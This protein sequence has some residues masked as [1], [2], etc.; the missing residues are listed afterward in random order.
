[1]EGTRQSGIGIDLKIA[2]LGADGQILQYARNVAGEIIDADPA[3]TDPA[4][5]LL[6]DRL[7]ILFPHK[8]NWGMIS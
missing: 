3:L 5:Q 8:I 2:N 1:L 7:A 6:H 4:H